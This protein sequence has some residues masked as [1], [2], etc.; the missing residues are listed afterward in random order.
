MRERFGLDELYVADLDAIGGGPGSP[1][2]VAALAREGRVMVDAGTAAA[3][4]S[5]GSSSWASRGS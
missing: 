4:R 5:H 3:R 1:D 2:V